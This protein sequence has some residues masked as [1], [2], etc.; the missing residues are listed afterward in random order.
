MS[1]VEQA[2]LT[3]RKALSGQAALGLAI[4][5]AAISAAF[6]FGLLV[7][8]AVG[9]ICATQM[10]KKNQARGLYWA[11]LVICA[12]GIALSIAAGVATWSVG[13]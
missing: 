4:V 7:A 1:N 11:A 10:P 5:A 8:L 2:Q 13:R 12:A 9:I 6:P 3:D